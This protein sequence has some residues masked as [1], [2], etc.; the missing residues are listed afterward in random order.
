M[1][2]YGVEFHSGRV[3][4]VDAISPDEAL[5]AAQKIAD[6]DAGDVFPSHPDRQV[7]RLI[8]PKPAAAPAE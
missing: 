4:T 2:K 1:A 3:I 8:Y 7:L 6:R 5:R